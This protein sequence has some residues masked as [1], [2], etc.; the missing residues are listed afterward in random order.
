MTWENGLK[1]VMGKWIKSCHE[2][3]NRRA[4]MEKGHKSYHRKGNIRGVMG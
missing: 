3:R 2:I 1:D 4:V